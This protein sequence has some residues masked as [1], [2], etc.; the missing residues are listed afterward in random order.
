MR[1]F[2]GL[3]IPEKFVVAILAILVVPISVGGLF[4]YRQLIGAAEEE[5]RQ[6]LIRSVAL[7]RQSID[8]KLQEIER[9]GSLIATNQ[10]INEFLDSPFEWIYADYETY[11]FLVGPA[12]D[13][14]KFQ[15]RAL[16]DLRVYYYEPSIP[17]RF[18]N[19]GFY[20]FARI[21]RASW[22]APLLA[23]LDSGPAWREGPAPDAPAGRAVSARRPFEY[24]CQ[25][26]SLMSG[27]PIALMR[28][29]TEGDDLFDALRIASPKSARFFVSDSK[30]AI[31]Y[32]SKP[33]DEGSSLS[34]VMTSKRP[35]SAADAE[36]SYAAT[37]GGVACIA[38]AAK[39]ESLG[40]ELWA[41]MPTG[42][43]VAGTRS[44]LALVFAV[45]LAAIAVL[46]FAA[47]LIVRALLGRLERLVAAMRSVEEGDLSLELEAG[48]PDEFGELSSSFNSMLRRIEGLVAEVV[49]LERAEKK[50]EIAALEAQINPHFLY[51]TLSTITWEA[52]KCGAREVE[53]LSI[54]L[55]KFYR[56]TL[57][58]G[59]GLVSLGEELDMLDAYIII[60]ER[61]M[62]DRLSVSVDVEE[63]AKALFVPKVILQPIVE[64]AI[65][66]GFEPR[67]EGGAIAVTARRKPGGKLVIAIADDG[68][69]M[70]PDMAW[71]INAGEETGG[72][73][74]DGGGSGFG[75]RNIRE[76]ITFRFGPGYGLSVRSSRGEGT[77]VELV[78]PCVPADRGEEGDD[79]A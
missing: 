8:S 3:R 30:G 41:A 57:S 72:G 68:V 4:I 37:I 53:E 17:E 18:G 43:A 69:G 9:T 36:E 56:A 47:N 58:R 66:H 73:G 48:P 42:S 67:R 51:N 79:G 33:G 46:I 76:R 23:A 65:K 21:A 54:A 52:R 78:L 12:L 1:W 71:R 20:S 16:S 27:K 55:S 5:E 62:G 39:I 34:A 74:S 63:G 24:Y 64:N 49:R 31:V 29:E 35:S 14:L 60:Q 44:S 77:T 28:L 10:K 61:R 25:V 2:S 26:R 32:S 22:V 40:V 7:A 6:A 50:A 45:G 11:D 13:N 38:A 70:A 75:L 15:N 59:R 19:G